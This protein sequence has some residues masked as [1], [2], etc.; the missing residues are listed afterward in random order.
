[1]RNFLPSWLLILVW[2]SAAQAAAREYL[3]LDLAGSHDPY[4]AA[5]ERLAEL[6][7]GE[8][9]AG[10]A[11]R[12]APILEILKQ[13]QPRYVAIVVRPADLDINLARTF[14]K[15]ATLVDSDPFVDFAYGFITSRRPQSW[16]FC[17][18]AHGPYSR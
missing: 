11:Q 17:K 4:H 18:M 8:I 10:D 7:G 1:M 6:H 2:A 12:L 9:V 3:I 15:M 5:A 16:R 14:L 13:K